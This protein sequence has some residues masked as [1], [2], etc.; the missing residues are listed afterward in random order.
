[1]LFAEL[2][3]VVYILW[4]FS[5][6]SGLMSGLLPISYAYIVDVSATDKRSANFGLLGSLYSL[7]SLIKGAAIGIS[8]I[9]GP[10]TSGLIAMVNKA[11]DFNN[12]I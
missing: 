11:I 10:S 5:F 9:V 4:I 6:V 12:R 2:T 8:L 7:L 3:R 1:M